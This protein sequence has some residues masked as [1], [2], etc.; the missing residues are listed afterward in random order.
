MRAG[1]LDKLVTIETSTTAKNSRG[2]EVETWKELADYVVGTDTNDYVCIADHTSVTAA[3]KPITGTDYTGAWEASG[4]SIG[5]AWADA[6][7][8][9]SGRV[10]AR[11]RPLDTSERFESQQIQSSTTH[12]IDIR[13][14]SDVKT[15]MRIVFGSRTFYIE[16]IRNNPRVRDHELFLDCREHTDDDD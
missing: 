3:N 16:G 6:T 2:E 12:Q 9:T 4:T 15:D 5:S 13:Y 1:R 10:W 7:A 11:I 14:R 8:Y